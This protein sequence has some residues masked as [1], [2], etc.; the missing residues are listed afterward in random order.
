MGTFCKTP[1]DVN[2]SKRVSGK[3]RGWEGDEEEVA[4]QCRA[5]LLWVS[6]WLPMG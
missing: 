1:R 3:M 6:A 5:I 4:H 2:V